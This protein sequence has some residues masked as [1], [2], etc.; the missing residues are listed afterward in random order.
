MLK[1][2]LIS[3]YLAN[4]FIQILQ[5]IGSI[6][7]AR[8]AGA[9][10]LGT[11]AFGTAYVSTFLFISD[12]GLGTAHIKLV[13]EAEDSELD[14]YI[15]TYAL[16]KVF[17]V[18]IFLLIFF[19]FFFIQ[20]VVL[21]YKFES[22]AHI[23]VIFLSLFSITILQLV[24][25]QNETFAGKL[26]IA[27]QQFPHLILSISY[28]FLRIL[29]VL[30]GFG[31]VAIALGKVISV[32]IVLPIYFYLFRNYKIGKFDKTLVPK[33]IK[34]S[35]PVMFIGMSTSLISY[36]DKIFLQFFA[37]SEQVG[38]Y[39]AGFRFSMFVQ[40]IGMV[41][42]SMLMPDFSRLFKEKKSKDIALK[43]NKFE[44]FGFIVLM[45]FVIL[46]AIQSDIFIKM[47]LGYKFVNSIG[48]MT[49][50]TLMVFI[51][52]INIPYGSI[53]TG[54]GKFKLAAVL[55]IFSLV[56]FLICAL[57]F[58]NPKI[59]DLGGKGMALSM[60]ITYFVLGLLFRFWSK[61]YCTEVDIRFSLKYVLIGL[62]FFI[63]GYLIYV[64]FVNLIFLKVIFPF[65]FIGLF[66]G[67]L[68]TLNLV[69]KSDFINLLDVI[70][71]KKVSD[72]F[73]SEIKN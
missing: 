10:V 31:A 30:L 64:N 52:V 58:P 63:S 15:G 55:N 5:I 53:I 44:R 59:L 27:K 49:I 28:Q 8:V 73:F 50:T 18:I 67:L 41:I 9:T 32:L 43:I 33:Y 60:L 12:L 70:N 17:M 29:V 72:Y 71:I 16:I 11:I 26:E 37:G 69:T 14:R 20:T 36:L 62:F 35:L 56:V 21:K 13:S 24:S 2:K 6:V 51:L 45:P 19:I 39:I 42:G 68:W 66:Y 23:K 46:F 65:I 38:F 4:L 25:F 22:P 1:Q 57:T 34:I 47:L 48:I 7:V 3:A 54:F 40:V 61:K